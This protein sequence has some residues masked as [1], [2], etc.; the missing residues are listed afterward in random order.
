LPKEILAHLFTMK[1]PNLTE[2]GCEDVKPIIKL[3]E[4]GV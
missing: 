3:A 2:I 1:A 4:I